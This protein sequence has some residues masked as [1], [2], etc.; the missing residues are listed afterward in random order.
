MLS[1]QGSA[2]TVYSIT[3]IAVRNTAFKTGHAKG[4][5]AKEPLTPPHR[6][7]R[8]SLLRPTIQ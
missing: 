1:A 5:T 7:R 8:N 6:D 2:T 3:H 4:D